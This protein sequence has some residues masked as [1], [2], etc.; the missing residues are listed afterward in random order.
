[1]GA[2]EDF[3]HYSAEAR[4]G[5]GTRLHIRAV[6]PADQ[7]ELHEAFLRQNPASISRRFLHAKSDLSAKELAYLTRLDFVNHVALAAELMHAG[8]RQGVG[9][10]RFIR[11]P[12][13]PTEADVAFMV[14]DRFHGLGI[15][16]LLFRHL[17]QVAAQAGIETFTA[18]V[19]ADNAPMIAVFEKFGPVQWRSLPEGLLHVRVKLGDEQGREA[20]AAQPPDLWL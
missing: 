13:A 5:D 7:Q 19:R 8:D 2:N 10:A 14:D 17:A 20:H 6:T 9:I 11:D 4:L 12:H 16:T 3:S 15:C 1:M 18:D